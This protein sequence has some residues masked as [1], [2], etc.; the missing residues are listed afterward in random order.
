MSKTVIGLFNNMGEAQGVV[1]DLVAS[2]IERD[3]IG[4]MANEKHV[5]P[6]GG[7]TSRQG[8]DVAAGHACRRGYRRRDRRRGRSRAGVRRRWRFR[9]SARSWRRAR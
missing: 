9:A 5:V 8:S 2:G 3:D 4:F 6:S 1:K 7:D